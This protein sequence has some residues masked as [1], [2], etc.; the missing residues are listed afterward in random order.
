MRTVEENKELIAKYPFLQ[1]EPDYY[2]YT[3]ADEVPDGWQI[4]FGDEMWA[5]LKQILEEE[6]LLDEFQFYGIK[7]KYGTLRF[8][9]TP[10]SDRLEKWETKYDLKSMLYC[11]NCGKPT[12]YFTRGWINFI[13]EDCKNERPDRKTEELTWECIPSYS[14]YD[15]DGTE[16]KTVSQ[17]QEQF[18]AQWKKI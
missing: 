6:N 2:E 12:K 16:H 3:W 8:E 13:C 7:E 14:S 10:F 1:F 11:I 18:E 17:F 5:E 4:A 15:S 9:Y